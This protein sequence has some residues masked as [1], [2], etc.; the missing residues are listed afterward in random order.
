MSTFTRWCLLVL[1]IVILTRP[2]AVGAAQP[3]AFQT[4][5]ALVTCSS[6]GQFI[7]PAINFGKKH[8]KIQIPGWPTLDAFM[9]FEAKGDEKE[10]VEHYGY[11]EQRDPTP[12][13]QRGKRKGNHKQQRVSSREVTKQRDVA[14]YESAQA[15][16]RR[17]LQQPRVGSGGQT[18]AEGITIPIDLPW[19]FYANLTMLKGV[20]SFAVTPDNGAHWFPGVRHGGTGW[21]VA[22][23]PGTV[24]PGRF[25]TL[26]GRLSDRSGRV[27]YTIFLFEASQRDRTSQWVNLQIM[28]TESPE[29]DGIDTSSFGRKEWWEY[30]AGLQPSWATKF[31]GN[32][33]QVIENNGEDEEVT[34]NG[35]QSL[36]R[37][38]SQPAPMS[39]EAPAPM[40]PK[41][42]A[43]ATERAADRPTSP[44]AALAPAPASPAETGMVRLEIRKDTAEG[45]FDNKLTTL[46][47]VGVDGEGRVKF[48]HDAV[49]GEGLVGVQVPKGLYY[50]VLDQDDDLFIV[51]TTSD[52]TFQIDL[53][54][55][56]PSQVP[57]R[58][59]DTEVKEL[60]FV[61]IRK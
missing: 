7:S 59:F 60:K 52:K 41:P 6:Q 46:R 31:H 18:T 3:T 27:V 19:V 4:L 43:P 47:V 17:V 49:L 2:E 32:P 36:N 33:T 22:I 21:A 48:T 28:V 61:F 39:P 13:Q 35:Q 30:T 23:P 24:V 42:F 10:Y 29:D 44:V 57:T 12:T 8:Q 53:E 58:K 16:L 38:D 51:K 50:V 56:G 37:R 40:Q 1:G 25:C 55:V 54:G 45:A 9:P 34:D 14:S 15:Y 26:T 20:S 11:N 5:N